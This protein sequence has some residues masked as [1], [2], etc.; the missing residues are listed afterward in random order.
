M[1][2]RKH[3]SALIAAPSNLGTDWKNVANAWEMRSLEAR[4]KSDRSCARPHSRLVLR[5]ALATFRDRD[6][7]VWNP[8]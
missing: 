1:V 8:T 4:N 7:K 6:L 3:G 5:V 2:W